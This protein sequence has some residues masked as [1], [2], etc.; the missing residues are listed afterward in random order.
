MMMDASGTW[1][2]ERDFAT[3]AATVARPAN[4]VGIPQDSPIAALVSCACVVCEKLTVSARCSAGEPAATSRRPI[5]SAI[6]HRSRACSSICGKRRAT[7]AEVRAS[8]L[9][10]TT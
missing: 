3:V 8:P 7:T 10:D 2:N 6:G 5:A 9:V 1:N 4:K